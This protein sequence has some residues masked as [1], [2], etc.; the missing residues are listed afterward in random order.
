MNYFDAD[1]FGQYF[2]SSYWKVV[3]TIGLLALGDISTCA[4][5]TGAARLCDLDAGVIGDT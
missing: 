3:S 4:V 2:E 5:Q 1:Y